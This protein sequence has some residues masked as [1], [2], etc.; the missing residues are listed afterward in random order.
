MRDFEVEE[1]LRPTAAQL[2]QELSEAS[3]CLKCGTMPADQVN[4]VMLAGSGD[5][6]ILPMLP[7]VTASAHVPLQAAHPQ[8]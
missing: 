2:V 5:K 8:T 6:A 1:K 7:D 4:V 3:L